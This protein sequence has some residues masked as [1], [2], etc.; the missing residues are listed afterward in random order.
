MD[1]QAHK[2]SP[3]ELIRVVRNWLR[4]NQSVEEMYPDGAELFERYEQFMADR[5]T[6]CKKLHLRVRGILYTDYLSV[7]GSWV[8]ENDWR[9]EPPTRRGARLVGSAI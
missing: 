1:I 3:K 2:D 6:M 4:M 5:P 7:L 8:E 9:P